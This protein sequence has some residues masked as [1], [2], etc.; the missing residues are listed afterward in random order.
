MV[1]YV[2]SQLAEVFPRLFIVY[3][4]RNNNPR[5]RAGVRAYVRSYASD[6]IAGMLAAGMLSARRAFW[7]T[8]Y[9]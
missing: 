7:R 2:G 9:A 4:E 5:E 8:S 3:S 1:R 6:L